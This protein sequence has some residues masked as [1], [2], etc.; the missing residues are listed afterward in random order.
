M[1]TTCTTNLYNSY[2]YAH[3]PNYVKM[4]LKPK[5]DFAQATLE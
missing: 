4:L 1:H 2:R 3:N 5:F